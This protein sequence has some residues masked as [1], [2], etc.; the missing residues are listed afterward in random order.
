M[1]GRFVLSLTFFLF[2]YN[3]SVFSQSLLGSKESLRKQNDVANR[4]S[5]PRATEKSLEKLKE[6]GSLVPI[7]LSVVV[8]E[9]VREDL[10]FV[11]PEVSKYL[12]AM[13][14]D[15]INTFGRQLKVNSAVR[16]LEYH[17]N[18]LRVNTNAAA[19]SGDRATTHTTGATVDIGKKGMSN[20]ELEWLRKRLLFLESRDYVEATEEWTQLV[21][22]VMVFPW[23]EESV[24]SDEE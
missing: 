17:K 15:F 23:F 13:G 16:T 3:Q 7:P 18:L 9:R 22:H 11:R 14:V 5:L 21:F 1:R 19:I 4:L 6:D 10:R 12:E 8:D 24:L 20:E 2:L